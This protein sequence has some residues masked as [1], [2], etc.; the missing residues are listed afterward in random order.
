M[1]NCEAIR[2]TFL[3]G[4]TCPFA[5]CLFALVYSV[6]SI[7]GEFLFGGDVTSYVLILLWRDEFVTKI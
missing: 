2:P 3:V 6:I 5:D 4:F 1:H 7:I